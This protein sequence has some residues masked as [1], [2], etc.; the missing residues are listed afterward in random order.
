MDENMN[1]NDRNYLV[2]RIGDCARLKSGGP[3]MTVVKINY[4]GKFVE[5]AECIWF[6][7]GTLSYQS[8]CFDLAT[9]RRVE[10]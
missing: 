9:L 7:E 6:N 2:V 10:K 3:L 4:E 5:S 1:E 8:K